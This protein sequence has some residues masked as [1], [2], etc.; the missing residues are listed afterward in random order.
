MS[1]MVYAVAKDKVPWM[2]SS[3]SPFEFLCLLEVITVI[4]HATI[5]LVQSALIV[6][7]PSINLWYMLHKVYCWS[8]KWCIVGRKVPK[9]WIFLP[10]MPQMSLFFPTIHHFGDQQYTLRYATTCVKSLLYKH[11]DSIDNLHISHNSSG[12]GGQYTGT[13]NSQF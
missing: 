13:F 5:L 2:E 11:A 7:S 12:M 10:T 1:A 4:F 6:Q 3:R 9:M 8:P